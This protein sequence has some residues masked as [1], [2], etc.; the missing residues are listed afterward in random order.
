MLTSDKWRQVRPRDL[1]TV[2]TAVHLPQLKP[3]AGSSQGTSM[4]PVRRVRLQHPAPGESRH[5]LCWLVRVSGQRGKAGWSD[6][7]PP[8]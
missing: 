4:I 2:S 8:L 3:E 5:S 1:R 7:R 6:A